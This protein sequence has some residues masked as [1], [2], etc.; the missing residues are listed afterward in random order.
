MEITQGFGAEINAENCVQTLD[1]NAS[2]NG[3]L[4]L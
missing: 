2:V 4:S 3:T 1:P